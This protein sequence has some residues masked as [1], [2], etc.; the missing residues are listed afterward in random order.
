MTSACKFTAFL[1]CSWLQECCLNHQ[2]AGRVQSRKPL[3]C[4]S[5]PEECFE[6][7]CL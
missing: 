7:L 1:R 5:C 3:R 6:A 2:R 4:N